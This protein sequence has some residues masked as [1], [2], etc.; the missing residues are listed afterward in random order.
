[1]KCVSICIMRT[2]SLFNL[3][4]MDRR[5]ITCTSVKRH[6]Q[7]C[8]TSVKCH[9]QMFY[10]VKFEYQFPMATSTKVRVR[11]TREP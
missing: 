3:Y 9:M 11:V 2:M 8:C 1:M 6:M 10:A 7:M 4:T 5:L